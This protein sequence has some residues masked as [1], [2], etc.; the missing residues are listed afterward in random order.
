MDLARS[1][2]IGP[3]KFIVPLVGYAIL[4]PVILSVSGSKVLG[5][6]ALLS[7]L[8]SVLALI[9]LGFSAYLKRAVSAEEDESKKRQISQKI[10]SVASRIY[11]VSGFVIYTVLLFWWMVQRDAIEAF[12]GI[13]SPS[14]FLSAIILS[15]GTA[16]V[17]L[18]LKLASAVLASE[19]QNYFVEAVAAVAP[20]FV[21]PIAVAG[22]YLGRPLESLAAAYLTGA[23]FS[24]WITF[25]RLRSTAGLSASDLLFGERV[26]LAKILDL[27][28]ETRQFF[29]IS[30][31][32]A[33]REPTLR[34]V[35]AFVVGLE[36]TAWLDIA[37]RITTM[38][39]NLV[40]SGTAILFPILSKLQSSG[41]R[42]QAVAVSRLSMSYLLSFVTSSE[43]VLIVIQ[44]WIY[45][46]WI[47]DYS[48]SLSVAT[49]VF[50]IWNL[51]VAA[52]APFWHLLLATNLEKYAA[53]SLW[54][55]TGI[56][57]LL[58]PVSLVA[59]ISFGDLLTWWLIG[60]FLTQLL[61]FSVAQRKLYMV[62]EVLRDWQMMFLLAMTVLVV[63]VVVYRDLFSPMAEIFDMTSI[64]IIVL[65]IV[66][67]GVTT[68]RMWRMAKTLAMG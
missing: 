10:G 43:L 33:I 25:K 63:F 44:G 5:L 12:A 50:A 37:L 22:A 49:L 56:L 28:N 68:L 66:I 29:Y 32:F 39:R 61:I 46:A 62:F 18:H 24:S 64:Q 54:A 51:S 15:I 67:G 9:D 13:Y 59:S 41:M 47:G 57:L 48:A 40:A 36:L 52:N 38:I 53:L 42:Q 60:A 35:A 27:W 58:I 21:F 11:V 45:K 34:F 19:Q 1:V 23:C 2:F 4:Y 7:S 20:I 14:A 30:V 16:L 26:S 6:W 17:Q 8:L 55:H 65:L 3:G 31:G